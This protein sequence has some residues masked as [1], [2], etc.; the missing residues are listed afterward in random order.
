MNKQE[1]LLKLTEVIRRNLTHRD[2][3]RVTKLADTYYKS[4]IVPGKQVHLR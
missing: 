2:Y 3:E 4:G 1:G